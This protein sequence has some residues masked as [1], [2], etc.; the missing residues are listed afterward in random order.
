MKM[1]LR[2]TIVYSVQCRMFWAGVFIGACAVLLCGCTQFT[3]RDYSPDGSVMREVV[4]KGAP[5]LSRKS[6]FTITHYWIDKD[7]VPHE[8]TITRGV[9]ENSDQQLRAMELVRDMALAKAG[10]PVK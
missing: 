9:D 2:D 10:V 4:E 3:V 8:E 7:G 6:S 1:N 5:L